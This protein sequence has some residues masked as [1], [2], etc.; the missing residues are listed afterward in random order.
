MNSGLTDGGKKFDEGD[1]EVDR[2]RGVDG[3]NRPLGD[4][5]V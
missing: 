2:F 4:I 5:L 3:R 1:K